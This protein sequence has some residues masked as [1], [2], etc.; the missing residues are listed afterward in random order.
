MPEIRLLAL[1]LDD[2]LLRTDLTI[3]PRAKSAIKEAAKQGVYV[4][5][6]TGRMY[7]SA[8]PYARE[9]QLDLPL[10]TYQ[11][12]LVK[13]ADGREVYHRPIPLAMAKKVLNFLLPYQYHLNIYMDDH[14]YMEKDSPE[15][16][17][18][19]SISRVPVH[20]VDSLRDILNQAPS[21]ILVIADELEL[22][23]LARQIHAQFGQALNITKSKPYFLEL[24]HPQATKGVALAHLASSLNVKAEQVMAI[25]DSLNDLDMI[26]YAGF[27]V[28]MDNAVEIVKEK[29]NYITKHNDD[30][31]VAEAIQKLIIKTK[32]NNISN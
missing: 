29:A 15:G 19:S 16:K 31:G 24:A 12:A 5:L 30:E 22:D 1:D 17:R 11:G 13:Y 23:N 10:I 18:Y 32:S 7:C 27:S 20:F 14:L 25:G 6:A 2:T 26:E 4:T 28:A 3:S 9:L 8:L 21:K